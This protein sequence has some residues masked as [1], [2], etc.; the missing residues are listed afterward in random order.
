MPVAIVDRLEQIHI[1]DAHRQRSLV[2]HGAGD[3]AIDRFDEVAAVVEV[4]QR[5]VGGELVDLLV[6]VRLHAGVADELEDALAQGQVIAVGQDRLL[7]RAIVE[8]GGIGR[9]QIAY[10]V[11]IAVAPDLAMQARHAPV[12]DVQVGLARAPDHHRLRIDVGAPAQPLALDDH[13]AGRARAGRTR[14]IAEDRALGG[15]VFGGHASGRGEGG[16]RV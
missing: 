9:V 6:V 10:P 8:A 13:H 1:D 14:S 7:D 2:A 5:V 16:C 4:G 12:R 11:L 15:L 3:F